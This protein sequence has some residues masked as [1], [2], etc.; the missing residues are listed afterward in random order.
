MEKT[1]LRSMTPEEL[2]AFLATLGQP[3]YRAKQIFSWVHQKHASAFSEMT[4]LPA[5][6]REILAEKC[7]VELPKILHLAASK[8]DETVK[9]LFELSDGNRIESVRMH[10]HYGDTLCIS[11]QVGCN[12]GCAF[13]ATGL[14]GKIRDLTA[15]EMLG[16]IEKAEEALSCHISHVVLMGMGEPLDNFD[17]VVRFLDLVSHPMGRNLTARHIT[18]ST[19]GI[20]PKILALAEQKRQITLAVSLHA[21]DN[22]RRSSLMPVNRRWELS[23]LI[24]ACRTYFEKTGRR[25]TF[26][27]AL[28]AGENDSSDEAD[29]LIGL[30][31]DFPCHVNLIPINPVEETG[32][33]P[34]S[35]GV[36]KAFAARLEKG[37][38]SVTSRRTLGADIDAACGQLRRRKEQTD[39][40]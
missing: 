36:V 31:K 7:T 29:R 34:P 16:Q 39:F 19:C 26:E 35:K 11:T 1:D 23:E 6:L 5:S 24:P 8:Q 32:K 13:C 30:L 3:A 15:A 10:Y 18:L 4:D 17:Q 20:V 38:I 14:S 28:I 22:L 27:Y 40:V 33:K 9:F 25:V 37:G 2:T 12:M 21:S